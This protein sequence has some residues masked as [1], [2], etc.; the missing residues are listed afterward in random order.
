MK[1]LWILLVGLVLVVAACSSEPTA[2]PS[3]T[4]GEDQTTTT[5]TD[6]ES[7]SSGSDEDESQ[8]EDSTSDSQAERLTIALSNL[9]NESLDPTLASSVQESYLS[10]IFD[11]LVGL[12]EDATEPS[13][14]SGVL[15]D[16]ELS[17]DG[18]TVTLSLHEGLEF[19]DGSP[20]TAADVQFTLQR[21]WDD[22]VVAANAGT[23]R[24]ILGSPDNVEVIDDYTVEV[25]TVTNGYHLE[26]LL[27]WGSTEF[28]VVPKSYI[29]EVG[30][31][32]FRRNPIGSGPYRFVSQ[33][34]GTGVVLEAV[35]PEGW[36][37]HV[38]FQLAGEEASRQARLESGEADV[39]DVSPE[40]AS[41]LREAGFNIHEKGLP[42]W[43]GI[44]FPSLHQD[45]APLNSREVRLALALA[46]DKEAIVSGLYDGVGTVTGNF[47]GIGSPGY[48][49]LPPFEYD[50]EEATALLEAAGFP[51]GFAMS[52]QCYPNLGWPTSDVVQVVQSY[53]AEIGVTSEITCRDFGSY[54]EDW[55]GRAF[56]ANTATYTPFSGRYQWLGLLNSTAAEGTIPL[57]QGTEYATLVEAANGAS[58]E[59][60]MRTAL[61]AVDQFIHDEVSVI[62]IIQLGSLYATNDKVTNWEFGLAGHSGN[63]RFILSQQ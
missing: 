17:E 11:P 46:I 59:E 1:R 24:E 2:D 33:Q 53:W 32:E 23:V 3:D 51:D 9:G 18:T 38:E 21:L 37:D 52:L 10:L 35:D 61:A 44:V 15:R 12:N 56:D 7:G 13:R 41:G 16:W 14:E 27:P 54:R 20:L 49:E 22:G 36:V 42:N 40:V 4:E 55:A 29:E 34:Q 8:G 43:G 60:E 45:E 30:A 62:P 5:Q 31:E 47:I 48:E 39:V 19:H 63:Y 25:R 28:Y 26:S 50:P 58:S 57:Q 6:D